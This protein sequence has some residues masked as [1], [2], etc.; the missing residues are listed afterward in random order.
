MKFRL[1][2][3]TALAALV[4]VQ[5]MSPGPAVAGPRDGIA[6][7]QA[8]R[9]A[10]NL[11]ERG[12]YSEAKAR[13]DALAA[14]G[15][16]LLL[17]EGYS[18]LC[19]AQM[20][21]NGCLDR[22]DS[23]METY[24][25][26]AL[27]PRMRFMKANLL[28]E[29][30]RYREAAAH[31]ALVPLTALYKRE[32]AELW[33]RQAWSQFASGR[34]EDAA[35]GFAK[36][37]SLGK[38]DYQAASEYAL[39]YIDY[40][41]KDFASAAAH[42]E[43]AA[44]SPDYKDLSEYYLLE[45]R[46]MQGDYKYVI[47]KGTTL[48]DDVTDDRKPRLGRIISESYLVLGDV[49]GANKY[50]QQD[51][52]GKSPKNR[53]DYFYAGSLLYAL[54]NYKDAADNYSQ[55]TART[56]SIGQI[57][58]YHLGYCRIQL[59]DKVSAMDAFRDASQVEYDKAIQEDAWFNYAKLAFDL[60]KDASV[61][62]SYMA[63]YPAKEKNDQIY[64]YMAMAALYEHDYEAAVRAYDN[65]DYLDDDMKGNYMKAYYLRASQLIA[66]G[67]Y[68]DAVPL[69]KTAAYYS[70]KENPFNQMARYWLAE[71]LYRD[72][73]YPDAREV[74]TDLYN[75][76]A[77]DGQAEGDLISYNMAYNYFK[78]EKYAEAM[79]WFNN[80]L[81][82]DTDTF[83]ADAETRIGDCYFFTRDYR[84]AIAAYEREMS[85]YPDPDNIY[86]SYKAAVAS[87]LL[88]DNKRK[89]S[90]L[91]NV[92]TAAPEAKYWSESMYELGRAYV[93]AGDLT[94]AERTFKTLKGG[95]N[96]PSFEARALIE[97]GM[98]AGN[99]GND[100]A[101]LGYYRQVVSSAPGSDYAESALLAIENI[102]QKRQDPEGY[103]AYVNTL[104]QNYGIG[105][106]RKENVYFNTVEQMYL[107]GNYE[108]ALA[109]MEAYLETYP[110]G[111]YKG[112]AYYYM[113]ECCRM[114][115]RRDKAADCYS[116]A[117]EEGEGKAYQESAI[118][119]W[120]LISYSLGH[121]DHA[122]MGFRTLAQK[123]GLQ[124]NKTAALEGMMRSAY[125][126]LQYD[127]AIEAA[128]QLNT[129][130][131]KYILAKSYLATSRRS[132]AYALFAELSQAPSTNEGA[133]ATYL[134]IQDLYDR[135]EFEAVGGRVYEFAGKAAGQNY[136][137]AKAYIVLGDTFVEQGNREQARATFE[138][139]RDGYKPKE[140]TDDDVPDQ[141]KI[142]LERL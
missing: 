13:F 44:K 25:E 97:L 141:V 94:S 74:L 69:L 111:L 5:A 91:E 40:S 30:E 95:T 54:K 50:Y 124:E 79:R 63:K 135:G 39:G 24:P 138:S 132:E 36:V 119:N 9:R 109:G 113:G 49:E 123:T 102:Y 43:E 20:R 73:Q 129:R 87:G 128:S 139:I 51:L 16:D 77:L 115:G 62:N 134:I 114:L 57:A 103:L 27:Y 46:F 86:P 107:G 48:Y 2:V 71:S 60:N 81:Q 32:R 116:L 89:I 33:Y 90:F 118:L 41:R 59:K 93:A 31:Y 21:E 45:C 58:N 23:Y 83:G 11:Y 84:S 7:P 78:E 72:E 108:K 35:T 19:S 53:S 34:S 26:S 96:D 110:D 105:D 80:Y 75:L 3:S 1:L 17:A 121:Y 88:G 126:G 66:A 85:D 18:V 106:E 82:A 120:S 52:A 65:I 67:S 130:E 98:I 38:S 6:G 76:S 8:M 37:I 104:G 28:F 70:P 68:R 100:D 122:Y 117:I 42:F 64:S 137:L 140:G 125:R 47:T 56:D 142:R 15:D 61:F 112:Q 101:A 10:V 136:W 12:L 99:S 133:E 92:R 14:Q 55:M 29:E 22:I 131:A 127:K 4:A